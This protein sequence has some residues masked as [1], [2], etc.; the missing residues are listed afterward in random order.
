MNGSEISGIVD[1]ASVNSDAAIVAVDDWRQR[2]YATGLDVS[3][4][5]G[6]LLGAYYT[7]L[8]YQ[9]NLLSRGTRDQAIVSGVAAAVGYAGG[10]PAHSLSLIHI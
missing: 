6:F 3:S 9:P 7:G 2:Y 4:R 8:S 1:A 10:P 5:S